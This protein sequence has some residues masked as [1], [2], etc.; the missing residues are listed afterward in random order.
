[1][2]KHIAGAESCWDDNLEDDEHC[3][4]YLQRE[5]ERA[6]ARAEALLEEDEAA[7]D[8]SGDEDDAEDTDENE[9]DGEK[10][11]EATAETDITAE[12]ENDVDSE[13]TEVTDTAE[14]A[15]AKTRAKTAKPIGEKMAKAKTS[16]TKTKAES[17]REV[18]A[19]RQ[20]AGKD[21]RPRDI[22]AALSEKGVEVNAS[23]VSITLRTMGVPPS[24]KGGGRA[25][26]TAETNGEVKSREALKVR[27]TA[28][29]EKKPPAKAAADVNEQLLMAAADFMRDAGS[30][31][32]AVS[33][34][35][36]CSK[37]MHKN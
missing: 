6:T 2:V 33:M 23:Q 27:G 8:D 19:A 15:P 29:A 24:R 28:K 7:D 36:L 4:A 26:V 16:G 21:L 18:I 22:I 13:D 37:V 1:M 9:N 25:V 11:E 20:R 10:A 17:I 35:Q 34:L 30:L 14:E 3:E 5:K 31:E 32:R 12:E